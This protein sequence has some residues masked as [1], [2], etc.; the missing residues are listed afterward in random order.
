MEGDTTI[1]TIVDNVTY[2]QI[3]NF[4]Q[5]YNLDEEL[6]NPTFVTYGQRTSSRISRSMSRYQDPA[7]LF[8]I[9]N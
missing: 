9:E 1:S 3:L 6:S 4:N 2:I 5:N 7:P 8:E